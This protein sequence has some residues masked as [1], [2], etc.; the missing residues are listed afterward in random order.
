MK[1]SIGI[2]TFVKPPESID[3]VL[4]KADEAMYAAKKAGKNMVVEQLY[5]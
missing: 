4:R 3:E 2:A 5:D 1:F